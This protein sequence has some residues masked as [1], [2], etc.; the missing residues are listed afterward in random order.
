M[1]KVLL[2]L[3]L[4]N[5]FLYVEAGKRNR[6]DCEK[7][8]FP[9]ENYPEQLNPETTVNYI[10]EEVSPGIQRIIWSGFKGSGLIIPSGAFYYHLRSKEGSDTRKIVLMR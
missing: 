10:V 4:L 2:L 3:I 9:L 8:S 5:L 7:N 6:T 1:K